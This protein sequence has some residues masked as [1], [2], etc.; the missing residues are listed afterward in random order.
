MAKLNLAQ[1]TEFRAVPEVYTF[2]VEEYPGVKLE[3]NLIPLDIISTFQVIE[4]TKKYVE[5]HVSPPEGKKVIPFRAGNMVIPLSE[6]LIQGAVTLV[7]MQSPSE[8]YPPYTFEECIL[9]IANMPLLWLEV[10]N[11]IMEINSKKKS[12]MSHS[13]EMISKTKENETGLEAQAGTT[14]EL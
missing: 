12:L 10:Q 1:Y 2:E 11:K 9:L 3:L 4:R 5:L 8:E 14:Q 13:S 6:P 7:V